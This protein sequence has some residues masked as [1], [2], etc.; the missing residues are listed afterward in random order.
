M[1]RNIYLVCLLSVSVLLSGC[2]YVTPTIAQ[3]EA[4]EKV[5][6]HAYDT[7]AALPEGLSSKNG[8]APALLL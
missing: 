2:S 4:V 8:A 5:E 3:E 6:E 1:R 7:L